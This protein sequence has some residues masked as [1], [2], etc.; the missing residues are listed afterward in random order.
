MTGLGTST[1][2]HVNAKESYET[3]LIDVFDIAT[4]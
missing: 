4:F 1:R 3:L 2:L